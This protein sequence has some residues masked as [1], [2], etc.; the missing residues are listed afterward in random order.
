MKRSGSRDLLVA[1]RTELSGF[2][3]TLDAADWAEQSLCEDWTVLEVAAHLGSSI[4]LTR[5]GLLVRSLRYGT[6][7][8]GA[9]ARSAAAWATKGA[10]EIIASLADPKRLGLGFFYPQWALC[11]AVVHHQDIRRALG[12]P[13]HIPAERIKIAAKV[14]IRMPFLTGASRSSRRIS[15]RATDID[16]TWG[17]GPEVAG[18]AEAILMALAGRTDAVR[19]L[20]GDGLAVLS[21]NTRR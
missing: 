13:R 11:E 4:G 19:D 2:L 20:G 10:T 18:T 3:S 8:D 7:T 1:E 12:R 17:D 16:W 14:L 6:G 21:Q 5:R 9:N 15:I